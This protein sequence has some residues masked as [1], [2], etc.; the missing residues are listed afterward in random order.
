MLLT[1]PV[2]VAV[3]GRDQ[4]APG[5][6]EVVVEWH[7]RSHGSSER[8]ERARAR[9]CDKQDV[10]VAKQGMNTNGIGVN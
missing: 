8:C 1:W 10:A 4:I 2:G 9:V 5:G 7:E 3:D 6:V